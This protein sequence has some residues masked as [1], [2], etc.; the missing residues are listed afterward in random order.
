MSEGCTVTFDNLF[1]SLPVLDELSELGIRGV[2]T[3]C[4]NRLQNVPVQ[5]RLSLK[6]EDRGTYDFASDNRG[7][8]IDSWNNTAIVT[9]K[10]N[11]I[12]CLPESAINRWSELEEKKIQICMPKPLQIYNRRMGGVD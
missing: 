3:L 9:V 7:N 2:G 1:T 12:K 4:Q 5:S 10:A 11:Y 8:M 6:K